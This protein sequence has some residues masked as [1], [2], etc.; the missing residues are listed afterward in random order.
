MVSVT[1]FPAALKAAPVFGFFYD[2][3]I[4]PILEHFGLTYHFLSSV[5]ASSN[6]ISFQVAA[7]LNQLLFPEVFPLSETFDGRVFFDGKGKKVYTI[8]DFS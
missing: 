4:F 2:S 7:V 8:S 5:P 1:Y 6:R 3:F